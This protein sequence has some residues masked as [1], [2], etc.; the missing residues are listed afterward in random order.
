MLHVQFHFT[1]YVKGYEEGLILSIKTRKIINIKQKYSTV[2]SVQVIRKMYQNEEHHTYWSC[3]QNIKD[4]Y[5]YSVI[6]VINNSQK[7]QI[8]L[9]YNTDL[10]FCKSVHVFLESKIWITA[11]NNTRLKIYQH[12]YCSLFYFCEEFHI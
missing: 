6:W 5:M 10:Q 2:Y 3:F 12:Y 7:N 11:I 8:L 9:S 4:K 1:S